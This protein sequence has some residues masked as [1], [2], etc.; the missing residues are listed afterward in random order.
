MALL[1]Q[2]I[3]DWVKEHHN[4]SVELRHIKQ[5]NISFRDNA[6]NRESYYFTCGSWTSPYTMKRW[7]E[8]AENKL[9]DTWKH[10]QGT[11]YWIK[12]R[13]IIL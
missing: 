4:E 1:K 6:T 10:D 2:R 13:Q 11:W 8:I 7:V 5:A 9:Y 3:L 12:D